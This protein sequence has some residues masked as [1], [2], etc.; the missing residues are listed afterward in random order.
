MKHAS[1]LVIDDNPEDLATYTRWLV[2]TTERQLSV[3]TATTIAD[4]LDLFDARQYD[5]VVLDYDLRAATGLDFI[6]SL[7]TRGHDPPV[8]VITAH[9]SEAVAANFLKAGARDYLAKERLTDRE[10]CTAVNAQV[11]D[12]ALRLQLDAYRVRDRETTAALANSVE[13]ISFLAE[14]AEIFADRSGYAALPQIVAERVV[15]LLGVAA[16]VETSDLLG[17][18]CRS[19]S[20]SSGERAAMPVAPFSSLNVARFIDGEELRRAALEDTDVAAWLDEG[21]TFVAILPLQY[22]SEAVGRMLIGRT[23]DI[24][25]ATRGFMLD[26]AHRAALALSN[27]RNFDA[28]RFMRQRADAAKRRWSFQARVSTLFSR[29]TETN[30]TLPVLM[31]MIARTIG[32]SAAIF[33]CEPQTQRLQFIASASNSASNESHARD[34]FSELPYFV[35]DVLAIPKAVASA[36]SQSILSDVLRAASV[37]IAS[38]RQRALID[39]WQP[40]AAVSVPIRWKHAVIGVITLVRDRS[41][42]AFT[43]DEIAVVEDLARRTAVHLEVARAAERER[44]IA[45]RFQ[46]ALLPGNLNPNADLP[47]TARYHAG[48]EGMAVGGDWYDVINLRDGRI[49]ISIGDVVGRGVDAAAVMGRCRSF[50]RA[51]AFE[52]LGPAAAL[53]RMNYLLRNEGGDHFATCTAMIFDPQSRG[54]RYACAGHPPPILRLQG[55][56]ARLLNFARSM[57]VGAWQDTTFTEATIDLPD[58]AQV[59]LY[60][61]GLVERRDRGASV[62]VEQLR[63]VVQQGPLDIDALADTILATLEPDGSDDIAILIFEAPPSQGAHL[64]RW[65]F[66]RVDVRRI[67]TVIEHC[68]TLVKTHA[69]DG[70]FVNDARTIVEELLLAV[71]QVL[72]GPCRIDFDWLK[73]Y[74]ELRYSDCSLSFGLAENFRGFEEMPIVSGP[75]FELL[76]TQLGSAFTLRSK[77]N[78]GIAFAAKLPVRRTTEV[79]RSH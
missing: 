28:E 77:P 1:V 14:S 11:S 12:R 69:A 62:G 47:F 10:L 7:S 43:A 78:G 29:S 34:Y 21:V 79:N 37:A 33:L 40:I 65:A 25:D 35:E 9:G 38:D 18:R 44:T 70:E 61:D 16:I 31:Q 75:A 68:S 59:V 23:S 49:F 17:R 4:A 42:E 54:L 20:A 24:D 3:D 19:V 72:P 46:V 60:T 56:E 5:C 74:P 45:M 6:A 2:A 26:Y 13:R 67:E 58:G 66:D 48:A 8:V 52:G 76:A 73:E 50:L 57:P 41:S 64:R 63:V 32:D 39:A 36:R 53:T 22:G 27:A 55:G 15:P 71:A 51:Y 30:Q